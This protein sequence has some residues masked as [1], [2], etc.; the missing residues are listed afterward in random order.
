MIRRTTFSDIPRLVDLMRE[1]FARSKYAG[2]GTMNEKE[3]KALWV[4][5]I[6][7]DG[8]TSEGGTLARVA[9]DEHGV[10]TGFVLGVLQRVYQVGDQL[11]AQQVYLYQTPGGDPVAT[12]ELAVEFG[13]WAESIDDV[14]VD[15]QSAT[16]IVQGFPMAARIFEGLG[17][18]QSGV[19]YERVLR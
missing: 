16:D 12:I 3:A 7:R 19:I 2:R 6:Q 11:E 17:Y 18:K 5:S 9:E 1:V 8:K 4:R 10:V 13:K 14:I 15:V